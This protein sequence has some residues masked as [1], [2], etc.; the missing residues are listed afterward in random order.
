MLER[1]RIVPA[2]LVAWL[3]AAAFACPICLPPQGGGVAPLERMTSASAL[4]LAE[5][6]ADPRRMI[7][8]VVVRGKAA[9]G[10]AI[11][12]AYSDMP[13]APFEPGKAVILS[14][15]PLMHTWQPLGALPRDRADWFRAILSLPP[16]SSLAPED[17]PA[18]LKIFADDLFAGDSFVSQTAADQISRAPYGA[19]R[20]LAGSLD[21]ARLVDAANRVENAGRLPLFILLMG[22]AGDEPARAFI[23]RRLASAGAL[24]E[25]D[26]VAA[27]ITARVEME[28]AS[29]LDDVARRL[30]ASGDLKPA[31]LGGAFMALD[32]VGGAGDQ[33]RR[34]AIVALYQEILRVRPQSAGYVARSMENWRDFSLAPDIKQA[35]QSAPL[36]EASSLLIRSYLEAA[37]DAQPISIVK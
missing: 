3:P 10:E 13:R 18:R 19:M 32:V 17:W 15:H 4:V 24:A 2:L 37:F 30:L 36:D 33:P 12:I 8:R 16:A 20:T 23:A 5:P 1:L 14:R 29:A 25:A 26:E 35:A 27:L 21:G 9:A 7:V 11:A 6:Q 31:D 28:G 22:I 34:A